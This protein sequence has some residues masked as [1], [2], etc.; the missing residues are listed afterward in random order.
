MRS[1]FVGFAL[2]ATCAM[3][4]GEAN[5]PT[6]GAGGDSAGNTNGTVGSSG[7]T[8]TTGSSSQ[9]DLYQSGT[10]I[11]AKTLTTP[12][13]AKS[14]ETWFDSQLGANCG[15][16]QAADGQQRC[17]PSGLFAGTYW[18]DSDCTQPL[19]MNYCTSPAPQFVLL[20]KVAGSGCSATYSGYHV[21]PVGA[22]YTGTIY[23]GTGPGVCSTT[24]PP[25][26][27]LFYSLGSEMDPSTFVAWTEQV[28]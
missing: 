15:P 17:L 9:M 21:F 5:S 1:E 16:Q 20:S 11:K 7:A 8:G 23:I 3:G 12:D 4:C 6:S 13:G 19:A 24:T 22:S 25:A 10:R 28:D 2:V 27:E 18:S 14:F 26:I